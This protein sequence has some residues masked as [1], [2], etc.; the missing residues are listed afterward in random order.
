MFISKTGLCTKASDIIGKGIEN[1][2]FKILRMEV[3]KWVEIRLFGLMT[4]FS[5]IN[6]RFY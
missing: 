1:G 4:V 5:S 2:M 3:L 6:D